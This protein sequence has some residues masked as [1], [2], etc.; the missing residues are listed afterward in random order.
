MRIEDINEI[1]IAKASTTDLYELRTRF[2]NFYKKHFSGNNVPEA[3]GLTRNIFLENYLLFQKE[4]SKRKITGIP[5]IR[6][7]IFKTKMLGLNV[8]KLG[9]LVVVENYV[10][11]GG[12][13]VTS[14]A[15]AQDIDIIIRDEAA[16][17]DSGLELKLGRL[18][19]RETGK[20]PHFVYSPRGP[21]SSYI[22]VFDLILR[23]KP[24]T[25]RIKVEETKTVKKK[26]TEKTITLG[27]AITPLKSKGGYG[28]YEFADIEALWTTWAQGYIPEPG[29]AVEVK[30]D[31]FRVQLHKKADTIKI[32]SED[33]KRDLSSR[34]EGIVK[35]AKTIKQDCILDG[36]LLIYVD[37]KKI[38]RRD[39]PSYLMTKKPEA[40][41]AEI[42]VFDCLYFDQKPLNNLPWQ[43]RQEYLDKIF[44]GIDELLLH[45]VKPIIVKTKEK[46]L[47]AVKQC[48]SVQHSEGAMLK[49]VNSKY[50]L[51]GNTSEWAKF[52]NF[53]ELR[54]KITDKEAK[55]GGGYIYTCAIENNIP[56]GRTYATKINANVGD[57]I[58]VAVAEVKYNETEDSFT[59]DN[60]IVR[61]KKSAGTALTTKKQAMALSRL[62]RT[63]AMYT[64]ECLQCG[65]TIESD[66]HCREIKCPKCGGE[67]RRLERPGAGY[68]EKE[69]LGNISYK[70]GDSGTGIA[71]IHI[72]GLTEEEA[73]KLKEES[74]RLMMARADL[75]KLRAALIRAIGNHGAHI[76]LRLRRN[77]ENSWQGA[78]IFIGNIEGLSKIK[79][80][81]AGK[82]KLRAPWKQSRVGEPKTEVVRGPLGW[83]EAGAKKVALFKPGDPGA[84]TNKWGAMIRFDTYKWQ[85]YYAEEHA[86]KF[87]FSGGRFLNGNW[88]FAFVPIGE[89]DRVWMISKLKDDDHLKP[90][91]TKKL[92]LETFQSEGVDQDLK[93]PKER[94][95]ELIADLRYLGNSAYPKLKAG[96]TWG[97]WTM[98]DVLK[99]FAKIVDILRKIY[100][101][102]MPP[103]KAD[104]RYNS[105]YWQCYRAAKK[106]M[107][108]KPPTEKDLKEWDKK[109]SELIKKNIYGFRILKLDRKKQI[110]GGIV[111]EPNVEDTQGD[112]TDP[113][114][115][116]NA[117]YRF[118]ERYS[119]DPRKIKIEHQG[120]THYFPVLE[121]F[122]PEEPTKKGDTKIPAGAW[123]LM[124]KIT[125][126]K[127][128]DLVEKGE[129][130]GFSMGGTAKGEKKDLTT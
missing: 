92:D 106:Y 40:F 4:A 71:Q 118:M 98:D 115:I 36:E 73:D 117:M 81:Q 122:Q 24:D 55:K 86:K 108:T 32:F 84:T 90:Q 116:E 75:D 107:K 44:S 11:I 70:E 88:L 93:N 3:Q 94:Y 126:K 13:F 89:G 79:E 43:E 96:E 101:P 64:C 9:T 29:I 76:D 123:W 37:N 52:K 49:V 66:T 72:M 61:S 58:E 7:E 30:Y 41:K 104:K 14:P 10:S 57:I 15:D 39:M 20:N 130:T 125:D 69:E 112:F 85:L 77:K 127:I 54:V 74:N 19:A 5:E 68:V 23:A 33:A 17:K 91:P 103:E 128:W 51:N 113:Q 97:K 120:K 45:R 124:I 129:I 121:C 42:E 6:K 46:F 83:M 114:E 12:S 31:G 26:V 80:L 110:A 38:E 102:V 95:R 111:Y 100:F 87:H 25:K 99:Y 34:L 109:R 16:R 47:K 119:R 35:E 56:I 62:G 59:W 78:E 48:A 1:T 2:I 53:K 50:P 82:R 8:P 28:T 105:S 27:R 18:I 21:H 22:P 67:M 60:P 63:K 65:H